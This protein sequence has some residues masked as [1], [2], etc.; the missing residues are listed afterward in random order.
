MLS[1]R[2]VR[3]ILPMRVDP[4][5]A[6]R[7]R[8]RPDR[9]TTITLDDALEWLRADTDDLIEMRRLLIAN[10]LDLARDLAIAS[11]TRLTLADALDKKR[12][13]PR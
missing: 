12:A 7:G 3:N 11:Q 13:A 4:S 10:Q 8:R 2:A 5:G 9:A 1:A 6:Y